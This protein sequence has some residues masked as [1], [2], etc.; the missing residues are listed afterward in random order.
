MRLIGYW[1]ESLTDLDYLPPQEFVGSMPESD[2]QKV[3][4]YLENGEKYA[5]YRGYS[6]CRVFCDRKMGDSE[7]SDGYWVWPE[8]LGHYVR[9]HGV[10][11]PREF[12][13]QVLTGTPRLPHS[14]WPSGKPDLLFWKQWCKTHQ[15]GRY[16]SRLADAKT[17]GDRAAARLF[18][19]AVAEREAKDGVSDKT[20]LWAGCSNWALNGRALCAACLLRDEAPIIGSAGYPGLREVLGAST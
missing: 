8:D 13:D 7:I 17:R 16:R 20:C 15:L 12:I 2:R 3:A 6:W 1:I 4:V 10:V 5:A 14:H 9:E 18:A 11:L 19:A